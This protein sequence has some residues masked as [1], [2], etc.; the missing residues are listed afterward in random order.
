MAKTDRT[1]D[2]NLWERA[3]ERVCRLPLDRQEEIVDYIDFVVEREEAEEWELSE[4]D[5]EAIARH[6]EGDLCDTVPFDSVKDAILRGR[7]D[8]I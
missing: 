3:Y 4:D 7:P 2:R 6:R 5:Y 8:E 1:I